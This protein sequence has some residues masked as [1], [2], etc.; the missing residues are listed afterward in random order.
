MSHGWWCLWSKS[1]DPRER[2]G[3]HEWKGL[4]CLCLYVCIQGL[5]CLEGRSVP[6]VSIITATSLSLST[7]YIQILTWDLWTLSFVFLWLMRQVPSFQPLYRNQVQWGSLGF[8]THPDG[9]QSTS[10]SSL[11]CN[12]QILWYRMEPLFLPPRPCEPRNDVTQADVEKT[13][14][15]QEQTEPSLGLKVVNRRDRT[16]SGGYTGRQA[17]GWGSTGSK[18]GSSRGL[19]IPPWQWCG[20][21]M[22]SAGSA[23]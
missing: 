14:G 3:R 9:H 17:C 13:N 20:M 2:G 21:G 6:N 18:S 11:H 12:L 23:V 5:S 1:V 15:R 10:A 8:E 19:A 7:W 16:T 4:L 22:E